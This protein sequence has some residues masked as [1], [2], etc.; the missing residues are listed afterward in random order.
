V[1]VT[2]DSRNTAA[3]VFFLFDLLHLDGEDFRQRPLIERKDRLAALLE[4]APSPLHYISNLKSTIF[5]GSAVDAFA[6]LC[7]QRRNYPWLA[8]ALTA[9]RPP[10]DKS[11]ETTQLSPNGY[12]E[13]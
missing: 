3:I 6:V 5:S 1:Q 12:A 9:Q 11:I 13:F 2:S 8:G 4:N 10:G 7:G